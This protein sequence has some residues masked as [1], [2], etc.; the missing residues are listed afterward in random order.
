MRALAPVTLLH[1][2]GLRQAQSE[3]VFVCVP[4]FE[5]KVIDLAATS[6]IDPTELLRFKPI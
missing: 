3:R 4:I 6:F 1:A 5:A 2:L